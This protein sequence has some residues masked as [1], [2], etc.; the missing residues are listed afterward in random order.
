MGSFT[1]IPLSGLTVSKSSTTAH[2]SQ[3]KAGEIIQVNVPTHV[4]G[5]LD[6]ASGAIAT[7]I[8]TFDVW[9]HELPRIEIY[10]TQGSMS[11]PDPNSF[12]GPVRIRRTGAEGWSDIPLTHGYSDQSRGVGVAD[13]AY[14]LRSGRPHRAN[15]DLTFHVLDI[16]HAIH[17]ASNEGRHIDLESTCQKPAPL[18]LDL[19]PYTLDE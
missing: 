16:M 6:F 1:D 10:G 19:P 17:D 11:V 7:I 18:P 8:T 13:M 14:A 3:P 4:T 9:A 2:T 5:L 15:G 12:G